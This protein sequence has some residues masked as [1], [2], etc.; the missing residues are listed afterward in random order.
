MLSGVISQ[1]H[2]REPRTCDVRINPAIR[3]VTAASRGNLKYY[4]RYADKATVEIILHVYL[5]WS[6]Y[7]F[8]LCKKNTYR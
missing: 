3:S 1:F 6:I 7:E 4:I 2:A 8:Y 5:A